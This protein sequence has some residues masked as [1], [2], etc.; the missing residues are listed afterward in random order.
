[1]ESKHKII[2]YVFLFPMDHAKNDYDAQLE[3][4]QAVRVS[5]DL[6]GNQVL[7]LFEKVR[8]LTKPVAPRRLV[9]AVND[10]LQQVQENLRDRRILALIM[11]SKG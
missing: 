11:K 1:M 6:Y 5:N 8:G 9:Y 4:L 3:A 10:E 7:T 2:R